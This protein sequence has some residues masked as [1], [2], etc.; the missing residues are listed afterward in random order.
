MIETILLHLIGLILSLIG[1]ACVLA[2]FLT[3]INNKQEEQH[4]RR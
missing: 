3:H 4:E 2:P 1:M